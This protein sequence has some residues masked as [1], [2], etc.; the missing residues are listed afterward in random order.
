MIGKIMIGKSFRGCISY[1]LEDKLQRQASELLKKNRADILCYNLCYGNKV[2]LT[3]QFTE[4]RNLNLKLSKPVMHVTLSLVPGEFLGKGKLRNLVEDCARELGFENNQYL[5]VQ[6]SDT[7]HQHL[8][9]IINRVGFDCRTLSDS[10]NYKRMAAYCRKMEIKY[11][12]EKVLSPRKFLPKDQRQIPRVDNRKKCLQKCIQDCLLRASNYVDFEKRIRAKGY[13]IIKARGIAFLDQ[14][15][16]KVKGSEVG[17]S[18]QTIE[19]LF[20]MSQG[21]RINRVYEK[22][23]R[24]KLDTLL[25]VKTNSLSHGKSRTANQRMSPER[26]SIDTGPLIL[27]KKK[28]SRSQHL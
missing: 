14:Q 19:K 7:Q 8:H 1:C 2:E 17:Y 15:K 18:L 13:S 11:G 28:K 21:H 25:A 27:Q 6:H 22:M 24:D 12:L 4:V 3:K 10:N 20:T 9:V 16:V 23:Q 5:A 26:A